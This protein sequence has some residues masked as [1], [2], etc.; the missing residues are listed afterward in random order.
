MILSNRAIHEAIQAGSLEIEPAPP[1]PDQPDTPYQASALDLHLGDEIVELREGMPITINLAEGK[2]ADLYKQAGE[3]RALAEPYVLHPQRFVLAMTSERIA[4]P[5]RQDQIILAGRVEGRSSYARSG[6]LVHFTAP[7][8]HAGFAGRIT[9]ELINL[10]RYPIML[11]RGDAICQLIVEQV[12]G[13]P[14]ERLSQFHDQSAPGG[15]V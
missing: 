5:V 13:V 10:G 12:Q 3:S 11:R 7:T 1:S 2:I 9:L 4:F 8:I 14:A 15:S 6:L